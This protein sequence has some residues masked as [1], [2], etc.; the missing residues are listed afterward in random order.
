M[1]CN[2]TVALNFATRH[3]TVCC[4]TDSG[5]LASKLVIGTPDAVEPKDIFHESAG[6]KTLETSCSALLE[7]RTR[8]VLWAWVYNFNVPA[9]ILAALFHHSSCK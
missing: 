3:S 9:L 2:S 1:V 7:V 5:A 8:I 6:W 4:T